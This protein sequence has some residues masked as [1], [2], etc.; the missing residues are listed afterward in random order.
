MN[1]SYAPTRLR[2]RLARALTRPGRPVPLLDELVR[3]E[4]DPAYRAL[5][6]AQLDAALDE[7]HTAAQT[8]AAQ[9]TVAEEIDAAADR[10]RALI[11]SPGDRP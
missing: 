2:E 9:T 8:T 5:F 6:L 11:R 4:T 10:L 1:R 7:R 3:I